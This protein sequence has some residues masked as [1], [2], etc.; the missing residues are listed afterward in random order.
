[1][2]AGS[3]TSGSV[4]PKDFKP[5]TRPLAGKPTQ[6]LDSGRQLVVHYIFITLML[7]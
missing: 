5:A 6:M 3:S 2:I 7:Q 1:L 4:N